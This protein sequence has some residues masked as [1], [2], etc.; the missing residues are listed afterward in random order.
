MSREARIDRFKAWPDQARP[1]YIRLFSLQERLRAHLKMAQQLAL[2][3][4]EVKHSDGNPRKSQPLRIV[5]R[6]DDYLRKYREDQWPEI[7]YYLGLMRREI[8]EIKSAYKGGRRPKWYESISMAE[9]L[10]DQIWE[11]MEMIQA[12]LI[13]TLQSSP[14]LKQS[15]KSIIDETAKVLILA[16]DLREVLLFLKL[17]QS[18]IGLDKYGFEAIVDL[19]EQHTIDFTKMQIWQTQNKNNRRG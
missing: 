11:K 19:S 12:H 18:K 15:N 13:I 14:A 4:Y 10:T 5:S 9:T 17:G 16:R 7:K 8:E 2:K 3:N 6:Q 1:H